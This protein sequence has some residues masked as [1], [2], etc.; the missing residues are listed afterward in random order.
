[1]GRASIDLLMAALA[2][3]PRPGRPDA[4][5]LQVDAYIQAHLA[6]PGLC[7]Q[8][9]AEAHHMSGRTLYRLFGEPGPTVTE[10]IR[11]YRLDRVHADLLSPASAGLAIS[12]IAARWGLF[13]MPH[14]SRAFRA[15]YG[16]T[17]SEARQQMVS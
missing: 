5:R 3:Q 13:D 1:M 2:E 15:R 16:M 4:V 12:R 14:F 8:A 11:G 17:P 6:D 10:L 9:V 7:H